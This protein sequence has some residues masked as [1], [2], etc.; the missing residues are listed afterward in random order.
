[1]RRAFFLPKILLIFSSFLLF[2]HSS[3]NVF[4]AEASLRKTFLKAEKQVWKANSSTY[5]ALYNKLHYYPL[6]PYL[7]QQR[8]IH[9]IG[10]SKVKEIDLFLKEYK[11]TP[12]DWPLRKKWLKYLAKRKRTSLFIKFYSATNSAELTCIYYKFKLSNTNLY[13]FFL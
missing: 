3:S 7:D 9:T 10:L 13:K 4:A 6:Q 2:C 12:L 5:K 8:L 1:M 11:G